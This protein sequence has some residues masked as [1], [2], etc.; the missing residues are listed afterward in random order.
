ML[1]GDH[2]M[3][4]AISSF[5]HRLQENLFLRRRESA[6]GRVLAALMELHEEGKELTSENVARKAN[7]TDDE[8][9]TLS[10]EK[11]GRLTKRLGFAKERVGK[12]RQ[13]LICWDENRISKLI[14]SYGLQ[15]ALP[16]SLEKPSEP[17]LLSALA[18]NQADSS[19]EGSTNRP[20]YCPPF[21]EAEPRV[22]ADRADGADS[23]LET[24]QH[25]GL[26]K[27]TERTIGQVLDIWAARGK[28]VIN[29]GQG[30]S[31][32][33]LE[34]FLSLRDISERH[35]AAIKTWLAGE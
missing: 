18:S 26:L 27:G 33:D 25:N 10:A 23:S 21:S 29:L 3:V 11:V 14:S 8:V 32:P 24:E 30:E 6:P 22:T 9:E 34:K 5:V 12:F 15:M 1:N 19:Q 28:P 31:C 4:E 7:E 35:I 13:R 2:S 17:S 16:L 20:P